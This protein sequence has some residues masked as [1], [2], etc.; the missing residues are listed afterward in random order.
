M[1]GLSNSERIPT[2]YK[3]SILMCSYPTAP[4]GIPE[5]LFAGTTLRQFPGSLG[6]RQGL[7]TGVRNNTETRRRTLFRTEVT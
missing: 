1:D 5:N 4:A 2:A 6:L 3:A 7:G